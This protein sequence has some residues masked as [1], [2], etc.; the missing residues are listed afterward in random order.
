MLT[1]CVIVRMSMLV[2]S[3]HS[4]GVSQRT[5]LESVLS[6]HLYLGSVQVAGLVWQIPAEPWHQPVNRFLRFCWQSTDIRK[7]D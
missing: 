3:S 1:V 5:A 4:V 2:C 6:S 7:M